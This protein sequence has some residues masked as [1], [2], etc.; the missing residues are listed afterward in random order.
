MLQ[1]R[2]REHLSARMF[3]LT[4]LILLLA[5]AVTFGLIAWATPRTYTA[6]ANDDLQQRTDALA[7]RLEDSS[8]EECGPLLDEFIRS[9]RCD[10]LILTPDGQIAHTGS[11]LSGTSLPEGSRITVT[12][13]GPETEDGLRSSM[14]LQLSPG[15]GDTAVASLEPY[16]ILADVTFSGEDGIYTLYVS[17]HR[18]EENLAVRALIRMA[19]WVL[20]VL[21][22]FSLLCAWICSRYITRPVIRI[23]RI[24]ERMAGLDFQWKCGG[25]RSDEIGVLGRSLDE[26]AFRLSAALA[27]LEEANQAL[28]LEVDR[29]RELDRQRAEFFSAASHELKTPVTILKGQLSGMLEGIDVY[30]DRDKYLLRSLQV[31]G[32]MERLIQEMLSISR[33]ENT[34]DAFRPE[35]L[36]LSSLL[37]NQLA[38]DKDLAL[39]RNQRIT[40]DLA[41]GLAVEA[42]SALLSKAVENILSNAFL[43]SP[44]GARIRVWCGLIQD[45]PAFAVENSGVHIPEEAL[46]HLFEAFYRIES[47]RSRSTGGSGLGLCLTKMILDRHKASCTVENTEEGV[48]VLVRF[49]ASSCLHTKHI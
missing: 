23:S 13:S 48:Q 20:L 32:R 25:R 27:K 35:S 17:P 33:M 4:F 19:P 31:A 21:L 41:D 30:R 14:G 45:Q 6:V 43:Y 10:A 15:S 38:L 11:A 44:E 49:P 12:S 39:L 36:E 5:G 24:A 2:L 26:M 29:E 18:Q 9:S 7:K 22:A 1:K 28:Q 3:L 16:G 40:T 37:K 46:P 42:D 8:P 34:P 47:S